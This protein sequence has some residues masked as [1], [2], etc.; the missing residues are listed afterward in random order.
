[1]SVHSGSSGLK[2]AT[3]RNK[4][5]TPSTLW[6]LHPKAQLFSTSGPTPCA[7]PRNPPACAKLASSLRRPM[8]EC[9]LSRG[10]GLLFSF[11]ACSKR[12]LNTQ[13]AC[14]KLSWAEFSRNVFANFTAAGCSF[15]QDY[16]ESR[17]P[18]V[19]HR[20]RGVGHRGRRESDIQMWRVGHAARLVG[21]HHVTSH[22]QEK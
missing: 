9:I 5:H 22:G 7:E 17:T 18:E 21:H 2:I 6:Q 20:A 16:A 15:R 19:G 12:R 1:M 3:L 10:Q 4:S 13:V 11:V 8:R 14:A